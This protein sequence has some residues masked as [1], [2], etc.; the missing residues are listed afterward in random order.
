M[1]GYHFGVL[2]SRGGYLG[3]DIFFV[4]S[5]FVVMR[6]L[7]RSVGS[8]GWKRQFFVR[9]CARLVPAIVPVLLFAALWSAWKTPGIDSGETAALIGA[10][11]MNYNLARL[12]LRANG[13][14]IHLWS[15]AIEWHFYLAAPLLIRLFANRRRGAGLVLGGAGLVLLSRFSLVGTS[16]VEPMT[17]YLA[18]WFRLDGLLIGTALALCSPVTLR[19]IGPRLSSVALAVL[20]A[21]VAAGPVWYSKPLISLLITIPT[22]TFATAIVVA[23]L[24]SGTAPRRIEQ[25]LSSRP[26]IALGERSYSLYLWHYVVGVV[27]LGNGSEAFQGIVKLVLQLAATFAAGWLSYGLIER[28]GRRLLTE[29]LR[30]HEKRHAPSVAAVTSETMWASRGRPGFTP[31]LR[32]TTPPDSLPWGDRNRQPLSGR[33]F[34]R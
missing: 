23:A 15:L 3:V 32:S 19:R 30:P 27:V 14:L 25:V 24:A 28:P 26:L 31:L 16:R 2:G 22:A 18:T 4:L 7:S 6:S 33:P 12:A 5:G 8:P 13:E 1:I 11:T 9:R 17:A 21:L 10:A 34:Q 20:G 29:T